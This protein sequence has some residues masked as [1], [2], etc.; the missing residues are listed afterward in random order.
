MHAPSAHAIWMLDSQAVNMLSQSFFHNS[1]LIVALHYLVFVYM[2][3]CLRSTCLQRILAL[4][5]PGQETRGREIISSWSIWDE[6][7]CTIAM[8]AWRNLSAITTSVT[9]P[10]YQDETPTMTDL[11]D[12]PNPL[13]LI[14]LRGTVMQTSRGS[15]FLIDTP[16]LLQDTID[17]GMIPLTEGIHLIA[18][19]LHQ[20]GCNCSNW[21]FNAFLLVFIKIEAERSISWTQFLSCHTLL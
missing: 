21:K 3:A 20:E 14:A 11:I 7:S 15:V 17:H 18:M 16:R 12:M 4:Q 2:Y 1:Y 19:V 13:Q 5:N 9:S 8:L 10:Q 6:E